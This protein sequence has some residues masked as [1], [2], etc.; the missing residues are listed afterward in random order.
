MH[1]NKNVQKKLLSG[2]DDS[3]RWGNKKFRVRSPL[4]KMHDSVGK[5][6]ELAATQVHVILSS[7]VLSSRL[8][9]ALKLLH[10]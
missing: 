7:R 5:A 1:V 8:I 6:F 10:A 2:F 3:F 9:G 4:T